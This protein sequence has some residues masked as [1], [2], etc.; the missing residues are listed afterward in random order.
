MAGWRKLLQEFIEVCFCLWMFIV[1]IALFLSFAIVFV[2]MGAAVFAA[3]AVVPAAVVPAAAAATAAAADLAHERIFR[4]MTNLDSCVNVWVMQPNIATDRTG[5]YATVD[6]GLVQ[7]SWCRC[8]IPCLLLEK[9][10]TFCNLLWKCVQTSSWSSGRAQPLTLQERQ[11]DC[12]NTYIVTSS[13]AYPCST[14]CQAYWKRQ[15]FQQT[16]ETTNTEGAAYS[17]LWVD[18]QN[19]VL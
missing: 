19:T 15:L 8:N 6:A 14:N 11:I 1:T 10:N 7:F 13:V 5:R 9:K 12:S 17:N 2:P 4:S 16:G 3:A 18:T